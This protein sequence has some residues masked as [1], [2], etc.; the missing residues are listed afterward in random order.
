MAYLVLNIEYYSQLNPSLNSKGLCP[1]LV[2]N[3]SSSVLS[4]NA[5][6][7]DDYHPSKPLH[8]S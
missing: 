1:T 7:P 5:Q 8:Q 6:T 4:T 3:N 2:L